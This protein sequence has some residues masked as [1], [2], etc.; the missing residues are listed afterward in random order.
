MKARDTQNPNGLLNKQA[1]LGIKR[2]LNDIRARRF[3]EF[4]PKYAIDMAVLFK[5]RSHNIGR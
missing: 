4:T 5:K 2:G 1:E 3:H